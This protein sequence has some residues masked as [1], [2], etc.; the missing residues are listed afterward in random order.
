MSTS[1]VLRALTVL[2]FA[3]LLVAG[4]PA[5]AA[6]PTPTPASEPGVRP[7]PDEARRPPPPTHSPDQDVVQ[8]DLR[9]WPLP[10]SSY[11][12]SQA[13]GC[14]PQLGFYAVV[15]GCPN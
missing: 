12:F 8:E 15:D 6:E 9:V 14:V 5:L 3:A 10:G 1:L 2:A 13:F 4:N 11:G 7:R